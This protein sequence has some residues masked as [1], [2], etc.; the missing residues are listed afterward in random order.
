V[1]GVGGQLHAAPNAT[2]HVE[3]FA[4]TLGAPQGQTHVGSTEVTT[5]SRGFARFAVFVP[6]QP[7]NAVFTA[8]ATSATHDTSQFS[9]AV[10]P[11]RHARR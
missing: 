2:F 5:D 3:I 10:P 11:P 7:S 6:T 9:N 1:T 8:T 4:T